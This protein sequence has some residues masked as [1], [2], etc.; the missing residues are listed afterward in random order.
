[1]KEKITIFIIGLLLGAIISTGSIYFYTL[2]NDSNNGNNNQGMQQQNGMQ[3]NGF[4]GQ[5]GGNG[6]PPEMPNSNQQNGSN[7]GN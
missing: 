1:M 6:Q 4:D 3:P 5:M 7:N 2:A